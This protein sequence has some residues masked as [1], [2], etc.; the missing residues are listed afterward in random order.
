MWLKIK[1]SLFV[2]NTTL[3]TL[4]GISGEIFDTVESILNQLESRKYIKMPKSSKMPLKYSICPLCHHFSFDFSLLQS[5]NIIEFHG[6]N[7]FLL[8]VIN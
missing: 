3:V 5:Y 7:F 1:L 2:L 6:D 4:G 8:R